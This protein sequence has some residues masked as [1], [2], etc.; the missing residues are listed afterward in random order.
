MRALP[1]GPARDAQFMALA[2]RQAEKASLEARPNPRVG[3][4]LVTEEGRI[5]GRGV[6]QAWGGPHAEVMALREAGSMARGA[7]AYV[8]LEPCNHQGR[9][10]PCTQALMAAGVA[11]V[12][13]AALDP[14]PGAAG[15]L[16]TLAEAG[17]A[18]QSGVLEHSA[19]AQNPGFHRRVAGGLPWVRLKMASTQDGLSALPDGRSQWITG[20]AARADGHRFRARSCA[21]LTGSGTVLADQ[22]RLTA[23]GWDIQRQPLRVVVDR[24]GRLTGDEAVFAGGEAEAW[25]LQGES[26]TPQRVLKALAEHPCNEV[27]IEAGP[28]LSAAWLEAG[29]V[30]ELI[31]YQNP[32]LLGQG[33]P[34]LDLPLLAELDQRWRLQVLDRRQFGEDC[35]IMAR[36][37][38]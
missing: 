14:N 20:P 25:H 10:G 33:R 28:V 13:C 16:K 12:V 36:P 21:I 32:S 19:I 11:R 34:A 37:V 15:G 2:L 8:T 3:C 26:W 30:D 7:T 4:V 1:A 31:L 5:V 17:I 9:T 24:R 27:L 35:R 38:R 29:L 6:T 22:P 23:R 18:T